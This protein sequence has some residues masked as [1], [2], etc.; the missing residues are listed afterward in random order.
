MT[1]K[2]SVRANEDGTPRC[3]EHGGEQ[4]ESCIRCEECGRIWW[5]GNVY[6]GEDYKC[7]CIEC[8]QGGNHAHSR[9]D[10]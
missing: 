2:W 5:W 3:A 1:A 7:I 10:A 9:P 6:V 8:Y 4:Y